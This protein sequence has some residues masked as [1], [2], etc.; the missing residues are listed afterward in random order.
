MSVFAASIV[1]LCEWE[2]SIL[3]VRENLFSCFTLNSCTF[4]SLTITSF[5]IA[6]LL[7]FFN[8]NNVYILVSLVFM[9]KFHVLFFSFSSYGG[10]YHFV[11]FLFITLTLKKIFFSVVCACWLY[12]LFCRRTL[13]LENFASI[14]SRFALNVQIFFAFFFFNLWFQCF[15]TL[16]NK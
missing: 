9:H 15:V 12:F 8:S 2:F 11:Y 6:F 13:P 14:F 10:A 7:V 1:G 5:Y 16:E 3:Y 4:C